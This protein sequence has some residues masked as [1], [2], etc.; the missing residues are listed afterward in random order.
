MAT[1]GELRKRNPGAIEKIKTVRGRE[2]ERKR[3]RE[4]E[5][6]RSRTE[7]GVTPCL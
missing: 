7:A 5:A 3:W 1:A 2:K 6:T 4:F